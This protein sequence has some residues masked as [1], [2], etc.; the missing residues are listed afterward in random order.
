MGWLSQSPAATR[1][2]AAVTPSGGTA[3]SAPRLPHATP[4]TDLPTGPPVRS[5]ASTVPSPP[6]AARRSAS[7]ACAASATS[8][9][10]SWMRTW[11]SS[12]SW[13]VAHFRRSRS[14]RSRS[15]LGWTTRP[16]RESATRRAYFVT[17]S[18]A[19]IP[20]CSVQVYWIVPGFFGVNA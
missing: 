19:S 11:T 12:T 8:G 1:S 2:S 6:T 17:V 4:S 3:A 7:A 5:A 16:S 9:S 15:R 14:G 13:S 20:R 10:L 18:V